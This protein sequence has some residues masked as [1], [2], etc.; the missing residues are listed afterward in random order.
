MEHA[1]RSKHAVSG[2]RTAQRGL[3]IVE[4]MIGLTVVGVFLAAAAYGYQL[5]FTSKGQNEMKYLDQAIECSRQIRANAPTFAGTTTAMMAN[6]NCFPNTLVVNKGTPGATVTNSF[7]GS[8]TT[9]PV[10]L[11]ATSDGLEFTTT[12]VPSDICVNML[13]LMSKPAR[14]T[15]Q[16]NGVGGAT[17]VMALGAATAELDLATACGAGTFAT[18]RFAVTKS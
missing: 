8:I 18:I 16:A 4:L 12:Q 11:N 5:I 9:T 15:I 6:N 1:T 14:I 10:N 3:T 13:R 2:S 7:G 17:T